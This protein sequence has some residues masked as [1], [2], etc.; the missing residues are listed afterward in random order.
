MKRILA[1]AFATLSVGETAHAYTREQIDVLNFVSIAEYAGRGDNCPFKLIESNVHDELRAAGFTQKDFD[2]SEYGELR[3]KSL[4][5]VI[6]TYKINPSAACTAAW[7]MF[8]PNG[9]YKR[10]MLEAK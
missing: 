5:P 10:Q 6:Q 9:G 4:V 1:V 2:S 3:M 8:G 7:S